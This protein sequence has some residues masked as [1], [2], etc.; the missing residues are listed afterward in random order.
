[1]RGLWKFVTGFVAV[2][3]LGLLALTAQPKVMLGVD[4][5]QGAG[6]KG[7]EGKKVGL[8]TNPSGVDSTGRATVEILFT[9]KE[10][11][12]VA[13]F[14]PEH[15]IYGDR[16]AGEKVAKRTD[17]RTG[18]PVYSLYGD[19]KKP[20]PEML[21][22]IDVLIYDI[23]DIGCRSYTYISTMGL[24]MEAAGAAGIEFFVLDRPN[25]LG[26]DRVEGPPMEKAYQSF[27]GQWPIPYIYGMTPGELANMIKGEGWIET[28]PKLV[29]VPMRGWKRN[30]TWRDT[31]LAWVPT[32]P[33][34][35]TYQSA[36][37]YAVTGLIGEG[38]KVNHGIGSRLPFE[39]L[40]G[41]DFNAFELSEKLNAGLKDGGFKNVHLRPAFWVPL[42]GDEAGKVVQGVQILLPDAR[43]TNLGALSMYL[44]GTLLAEKGD[45]LYKDGATVDTSLFVKV[46][47]G[48]KILEHF[49]DK[50]SWKELPKSW[51]THHKVFQVLRKNYLIK[52]Y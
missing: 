17:E 32:S 13:L 35:P 46:C 51:E 45:A 47:G 42:G 39:Y 7:L 5:L 2:Q 50:K 20:T 8:I 43:Q 28:P 49:K 30:M 29:I 19:T 6:F 44:L 41:A 16:P 40:G 27:V 9:A 1:M 24:A 36:V 26:G 23:Q 33:N 31:G 18:L 10:V 37:M 48:P 4:T 3:A 15:G 34:I 52:S 21:E 11:N 22:G 14:A 38:L 12:L 25:P